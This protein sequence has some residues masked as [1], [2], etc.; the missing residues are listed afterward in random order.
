MDGSAYIGSASSSIT[1]EL[2]HRAIDFVALERKMKSNGG[3]TENR[4]TR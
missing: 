3:C 2:L 4:G 1:A